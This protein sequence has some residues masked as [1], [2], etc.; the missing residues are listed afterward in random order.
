[1]KISPRR[2][3]RL[4]LCAVVTILPAA[5]FAQAPPVLVGVGLSYAHATA[6][7]GEYVGG[8]YGA[9]AV[10]RMPGRHFGARVDADFLSFPTTT[11]ARP[12]LGTGPEVW[13][14]TSMKSF[15]LTV[16][17][18]ARLSRGR[19]SAGV[20]GGV[21]LAR[22]SNSSSLTGLSSDPRFGGAATFGDVT[23]AAQ[24][25]AIFG[26]EVGSGVTMELAARYVVTG[27]TSFVTEENLRAGVIS[28]L[29]MVPTPTRASFFALRLGVFLGQVGGGS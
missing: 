2:V 26:L 6:T 23:V 18:E 9:A 20:F 21:G 3:T 16:G 8:A 19:F 1:M 29:Y 7:L 15:T 13:I 4:I 25:G 11:S 22:F 24:G 5:A 12:F 28:G 14:S 10:V 17:P 27:E